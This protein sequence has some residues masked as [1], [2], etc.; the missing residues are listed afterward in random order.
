MIFTVEIVPKGHEYAVTETVVHEGHA[1]P[2]WDD[3]DVETVLK[4]I[5]NALDRAANPDA[6]DH[7][8][9]TLRGFSWIVEPSGDEVVIAVEV[10][11]GAAVAGPFDIEASRLNEMITRVLSATRSA[12][13]G[14]IH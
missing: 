5:L 2:A 12:P 4:A 8:Q 14:R 11:S 13:P 7:R 9:V 1:P 10:P 3:A 6:G